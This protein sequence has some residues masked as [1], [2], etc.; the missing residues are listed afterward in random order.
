MPVSYDRYLGS[1]IWPHHLVVARYQYTVLILQVISHA[2]EQFIYPLV[3]DQPLLAR[4]ARRYGKVKH[5]HLRLASIPNIPG[6][7][8]RDRDVQVHVERLLDRA[9]LSE[10][11]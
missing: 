6:P 7:G 2:S 9:R 8:H 4:M 10:A 3:S 11:G 5:F 1:S